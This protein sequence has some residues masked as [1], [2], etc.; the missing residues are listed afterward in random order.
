MAKKIWKLTS[1]DQDMTN[2][3]VVVDK[4]P[5]DVLEVGCKY[6]SRCGEVWEVFIE[7]DE[8]GTYSFVARSGDREAWFAKGGHYF[9]GEMDKNDLIFKLVE[10]NP[11]QVEEKPKHGTGDKGK[12]Y[13][14]SFK[15]RLSASDIA[16][17]YV[18]VNLDPYRISDV[19]ELGGWREH[20][21]KKA[22]RGTLKG[23][24]EQELID[25]LRACIDRAEQMMKEDWKEN[26]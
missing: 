19:Y 13:R 22:L 8:E 5:F 10:T 14:H 26:E 23:H 6:E 21:V 25:E 18:T 4:I 16:N 15:L 12:H 7:S 20:V 1:E 24:S 2:E 9:Y 11:G 3:S 17:G